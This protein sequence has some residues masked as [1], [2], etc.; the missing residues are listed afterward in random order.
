MKTAKIATIAHNARWHT[1]I[2]A[3]KIIYFGSTKS[4]ARRAALNSQT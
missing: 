4:R 2:G 1:P 3:E